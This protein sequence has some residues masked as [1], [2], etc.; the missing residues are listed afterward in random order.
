MKY[1]IVF[2]TFLYS[3]LSFAAVVEVDYKS[4]LQQ[5]NPPQVYLNM[6]E[7][8]V[9]KLSSLS[10]L[11]YQ[12]NQKNW[13]ACAKQAANLFRVEKV[14]SAWVLT[15][16]LNCSLKIDNE[17]Q[18]ISFLKDSLK[19][20][21]TVVDL[22]DRGPWK[23]NLQLYWNQSLNYLSTRL[24]TTADQKKIETYAFQRFE[25]LSS[26]NKKIFITDRK[27]DGVMAPL[28]LGKTVRPLD[29]QEAKEAALDSRITK[30]D[31]E[32]KY[33]ELISVLIQSIREYP[34][35]TLT[36][37]WKDKVYEIWSLSKDT[38]SLNSQEVADVLLQAD[39]E[40][41]LEMAQWSY[42][43]AY[44]RDA[45][46]L[47]EKFTRESKDLVS[48]GSALGILSR[49]LLFLGLYEEAKTNFEILADKYAAT[50]DGQNAVF[51]LGLLHFR[52]A[53]YQISKKYFERILLKKDKNDLA[54]RYW[55]IRSLEE[56]KDSQTDEE[57]RKLVSD[58]PAS[59]YGLKLNAELNGG[60]LVFDA[61]PGKV[62][63]VK[64]VFIADQAD[65]WKRF[66]ALSKAGWVIE[67]ASE[68][69]FLVNPANDDELMSMALLLNHWGQYNSAI[70]ISNQIF[71]Q[72]ESFKSWFWM[73]K[74]FPMVYADLISAEAARYKL[75]PY[76]FRSLIRQESA[77]ALRAVS[78]SNALGLMQMIPPTAADVS[79]R[80]KMKVSIPEDM[81]RPEINIKMG[82][83]YFS[84][85]LNSFQGHIPLSLA[86]Y[87]AGPTRIN[88]WLNSR[89]ETK[90]LSKNFSTNYR[91]EIWMDELPWGETSFYV[92]AILRNM[93]LYSRIEKEDFELKPSFW[94][95]FYKR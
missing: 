14:L 6:K 42:R 4:L 35:T 85:L 8:D 65:T 53:N 22:L 25:Y 62:P 33:T 80:M 39:P 60:K 86:S 45:A 11:K 73:K 74:T 13:T 63:T 92:K 64:S 5:K 17:K 34:A 26:E 66:E 69:T 24:T 57:K 1:N 72:N 59:Y 55:W 75:N 93:I 71:D 50:E 68:F 89:P 27:S 21:D 3:T 58:F 54:S 87:N 90:D 76:V 77:F 28:G 41:L 16:G 79:Q 88:L 23:N 15:T 29:A 84:D 82:S 51:R 20:L 56:L 32:K 70:R 10:L 2:T 48:R 38:N 37:K 12:E 19:R 81:Y 18:K 7:A 83:F 46:R 91:D 61:N 67:A 52:L 44:Y 49:S 95:D 30:L 36:K 43:R 94:S 40:F 9:K 78:T 47:S 31:Q